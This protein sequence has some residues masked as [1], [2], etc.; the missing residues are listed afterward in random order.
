[1]RNNC[2]IPVEQLKVLL[3]QMGVHD[4]Q[5]KPFDHAESIISDACLITSSSRISV[6][7]V[8]PRANDYHREVWALSNIKSSIP[9]PGFY[10]CLE[11]KGDFS[12]AIL[13]EYLPEELLHDNL[14]NNEI[15][16]QIG[17]I[18][19]RIHQKKEG[20]Y[21]EVLPSERQNTNAYDYFRQKFYEELEE[22]KDLI[23]GSLYKKIHKFLTDQKQNLLQTDGPCLVHRDFRPGNILVKDN[24]VCGIID[25]SGVRYGFAEQDI[26]NIM[27]SINKN[28]N[29]IKECFLKGYEGIRTVPDYK[30][31][32]PLIN[33]GRALGIV[34][35]LS[36]KKKRNPAEESLFKVWYDTLNDFDY[37]E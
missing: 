19:A 34:G 3:E 37:H 9:V 10:R 33:I 17:D 6:L 36:Q 20:Y 13:M 15:A 32:T 26:C 23:S 31:I 16:F 1:M 35:Y 30:H 29:K 28:Q 12:G 5:I 21:G 14:W 11:A 7:K 4:A 2:K 8:Y 27:I 25:W 24:N 18:L 22:C